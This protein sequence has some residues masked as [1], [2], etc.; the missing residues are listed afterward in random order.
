MA[1][2]LPALVFELFEV[3]DSER[4][5]FLPPGKGE[6]MSFYEIGVVYFI[7]AYRGA[8]GPFIRRCMPQW[9]RQGGRKAGK[10]DTEHCCCLGRAHTQ[11]QT[12][13]LPRRSLQTGAL[14][15]TRRPLGDV[16]SPDTTAPE[17]RGFVAC[18]RR[19]ARAWRNVQPLPSR[20][21]WILLLYGLKVP[22]SYA[23]RNYWTR[24]CHRRLAGSWV[25]SARLLCL[26]YLILLGLVFFS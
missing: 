3:S 1:L 20:L 2:D 22:S 25:N 21:G 9:R 5:H 10:Y 26:Y 24:A 12:R 14:G 19:S 8:S 23:L 17:K 6:L 18:R 13:L 15:E 7:L 11:Q 16:R 4:R